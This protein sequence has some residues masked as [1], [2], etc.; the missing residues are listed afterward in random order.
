MDRFKMY[1]AEPYVGEDGIYMPIHPYIYDDSMAD[2]SLLMSKEIF[3]E[4][5]KEYI[6]KE[7]LFDCSK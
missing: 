2:Y 3:Q 7:G 4:A 6:L 1:K 5:F